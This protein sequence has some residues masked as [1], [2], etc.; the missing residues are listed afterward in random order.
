MQTNDQYKI[1][2]NFCVYNGNDIL[3]KYWLYFSYETRICLENNVQQPKG[4]GEVEYKRSLRKDNPFSG[5]FSS[6][7]IIIHDDDNVYSWVRAT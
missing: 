2:A 5:P 4:K 6:W 3:R 7:S 1:L